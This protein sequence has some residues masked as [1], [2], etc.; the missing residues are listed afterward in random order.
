[1]ALAGD[2][3]RERA[4]LELRRHYLAGRLS[5]AELDERLGLALGARTRGETRLATSQLPPA[6]LQLDEV[7]VPAVRN[8]AA[9]ARHAALVAVIGI[10]WLMLTV[11]TFVAFVAWVAV[12]GATTAGLVAFPL[13][14]LVLSALLFRRTSIS[15]RRLPRA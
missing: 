15:R 6:W 9:V 11:A 7:V 8:A 12:Q 14:W 4:A 10:V 13:V 1:M 2:R 3:D 5:E